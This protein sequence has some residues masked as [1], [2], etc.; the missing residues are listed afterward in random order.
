MTPDRQAAGRS[1][2]S[3]QPFAISHLSYLISYRQQTQQPPSHQPFTTHT[4]SSS[5]L[6]GHRP[7]LLLWSL[8]D[9][10]GGWGIMPSWLYIGYV[11]SVYSFVRQTS[12]F[13]LYIYNILYS[14]PSRMAA[15]FACHSL[16]LS[17]YLPPACSFF[18]PHPLKHFY[19]P[20][21]LPS[22]AHKQHV[23][24]RLCSH[25]GLHLT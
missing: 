11:N 19:K 17:L 13:F 16:S 18:P 22:S 8:V 23:P 6:P 21:W 25:R 4:H 24:A 9:W 7:S 3:K 14:C 12:S 5:F 1:S 2:L 20:S 10:V 15:L